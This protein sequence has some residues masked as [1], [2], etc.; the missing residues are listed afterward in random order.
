MSRKGPNGYWEK[1]IKGWHHI[2][3]KNGHR[4]M[5]K[6]NLKP[7]ESLDVGSR[8]Y[9]V[10]QC[11]VGYITSLE[12]LQNLT[13]T[14]RSLH[15]LV[16]SESCWSQ[17][18]RTKFGNT[19]WL[20]HVRRVFYPLYNQQLNCHD[21]IERMENDEIVDQCLKLPENFLRNRDEDYGKLVTRA[22][23]RC[24]RY[25]LE[26]VISNGIVYKDPPEFVF[27]WCVSFNNVHIEHLTDAQRRRVPL[28]KLTYF[29]LC[30]SRHVSVVNFDII[31][32]QE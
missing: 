20:R 14:C 11:V 24:Y 32:P 8:T 23:L 2:P 9:S 31:R 4:K 7:L 5:P 17:F 3:Y 18:I 12:D 13:R 27:R 30:D 19:L 21:D 28:G 22:I 29:Y 25:C 10:W 26:K 1:T 15:Q 16:E 6:A